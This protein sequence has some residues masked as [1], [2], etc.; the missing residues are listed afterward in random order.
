MSQPIVAC[1]GSNALLTVNGVAVHVKKW[2]LKV[3]ADVIKYKV[4]GQTPDAD[5]VYWVNKI[6]GGFADGTIEIEGYW[7]SN[8]VA[9]SKITGTNIK[10]RPGTTAAGSIVCSFKSGDA[11]TA[12][13]I[14]SMLSGSID[15]DATTPSP[16]SAS[17]E[18]DGAVTYPT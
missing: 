8:A 11:F 15:T 7:D 16:F 6:V 13:V 2:V 17:C 10:L 3:L 1:A 4:T 14:V 12:N 18:I 9:A 5:G